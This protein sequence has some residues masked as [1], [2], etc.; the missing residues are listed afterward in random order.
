MDLAA[1]SK[2]VVYNR[3]S[4]SQVSNLHPRVVAEADEVVRNI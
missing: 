4:Q 2:D 3:S 1:H